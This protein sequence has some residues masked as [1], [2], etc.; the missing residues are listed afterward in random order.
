[1]KN[2]CYFLYN[3]DVKAIDMVKFYNKLIKQINKW[4]SL[5][6]KVNDDIMY[7]LYSFKVIA[8]YVDKER[9]WF[10]DIRKPETLSKESRKI[11]E[12]IEKLK[13]EIER[14]DKVLAEKKW[15]LAEKKWILAEKKAELELLK[16]IDEWLD[17]MLEFNKT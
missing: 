5:W 7:T 3:I 12:R 15:I 2:V 1:M 16:V 14:K 6:L 11:K 13:Q 4:K 10:L 9:D 8:E 17:T